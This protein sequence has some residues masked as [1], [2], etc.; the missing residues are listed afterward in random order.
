MLQVK[1]DQLAPHED[2]T[3]AKCS[4]VFSSFDDQAVPCPSDVAAPNAGTCQIDPISPE[5]FGTAAP[6]SLLGSVAF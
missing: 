5:D 6:H 1:V 2:A 3:D 4:A